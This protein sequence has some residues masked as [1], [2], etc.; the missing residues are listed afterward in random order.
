MQDRSSW[1][2]GQ[3]RRTPFG[4]LP[5]LLESLLQ[6]ITGA[7]DIALLAQVIRL[8]GQ[9][10]GL[11]VEVFDL[12]HRRTTFACGVPNSTTTTYAASPGRSDCSVCACFSATRL[13]IRRAL[14]RK[15]PD[16]SR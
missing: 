7:L 15:I 4:C 5:F 9:A 11:A 1:F 16:T 14:P 10:H 8:V 3:V 12:V 13:L 6:T 2:H